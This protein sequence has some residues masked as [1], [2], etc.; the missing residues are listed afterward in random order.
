MVAP[1]FASCFLKLSRAEE[2]FNTFKLEVKEWKDSGPYVMSRKSDAGG[3]RHSQIIQIIKPAP[4]DRWAL[5]AGDV[6]HNLRS[7]LDNLIYAIAVR[8]SGRNPPPKARDL[9]FPV[10]STFERFE[11]KRRRRI[12][13]LSDKVQ[14]RIERAQ[15]YNRPHPQ[16]PPLLALLSEL[17]NLDKHNLLNVVISN[18]A[19]GKFSFTSSAQDGPFKPAEVGHHSGPV[20]SGAELAYFTCDPPSRDVD[21]RHEADIV[22]SIAHSAGP[23]GNTTTELGYVLEVLAEEVRMI[24]D[25]SLQLVA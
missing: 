8:E 7:V 1:E 17:D 5:I 16:V 3:R 6:V 20:E 24:V 11:D 22:I 10:A 12:A 13:T 4:V 9:Q 23:L 19:G 15:P 2:H 25:T 14:T 21:Y 18:V